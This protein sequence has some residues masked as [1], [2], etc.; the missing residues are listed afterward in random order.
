MNFALQEDY[1]QELDQEISVSISQVRYINYSHAQPSP[2]DTGDFCSAL[3][4]YLEELTPSGVAISVEIDQYDDSLYINGSDS[5]PDC[6]QVNEAIDEWLEP[7]KQKQHE[8]TFPCMTYRKRDS[9]FLIQF[10]NDNAPHSVFETRSMAEAI[11][12]LTTGKWQ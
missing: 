4:C 9:M 11:R 8:P 2:I 5:H 1:Y 10:D 12:A 3:E 7:K 6:E